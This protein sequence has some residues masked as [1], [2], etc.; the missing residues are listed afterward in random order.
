MKFL[1]IVLLWMSG[2][3]AIV[4]GTTV[5]NDLI[6]RGDYETHD[7]S[8]L[9]DACIIFW[10]AATVY[11]QRVRESHLQYENTWLTSAVKSYERRIQDDKNEEQ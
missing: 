5:V 7:L 3:S 10:L 11:G 6:T 4:A 2:L 8:S 1:M 9:I